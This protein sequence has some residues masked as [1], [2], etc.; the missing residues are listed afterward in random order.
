MCIYVFVPA[1]CTVMQLVCKGMGKKEGERGWVAVRLYMNGEYTV[2][3]EWVRLWKGGRGASGREG[4]RV[5]LWIQNERAKYELGR[6]G[7]DQ[8]MGEL[9][10]PSG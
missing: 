4:L 8:V 3:K 7:K 2:W 10:L 6:R 5:T 9:S 1:S